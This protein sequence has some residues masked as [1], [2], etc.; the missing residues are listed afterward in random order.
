M[1]KPEWGTK[2]QCQSCGVRFYDLMRAPVTCPKCSALVETEAVARPRRAAAP[3]VLAPVP[4]G[5]AAAVL[6]DDLEASGEEA[7]V[8]DVDGGDD[9]ESGLIEDAS[10][11]GE[12]DDD[13][14]EVIEHL[15]ENLEDEV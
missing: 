9:D 2:R 4:A 11:L 13:M 8:E 3:K 15:D 5:P 6:E 7:E 10:D 14:A 1:A 12:D